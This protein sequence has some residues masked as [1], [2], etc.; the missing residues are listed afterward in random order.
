M[1]YQRRFAGVAGAEYELFRL[2]VPHHDR[3]QD[4]IGESVVELSKQSS[5]ADLRVADIGCGYGYTSLLILDML[6]QARIEA[7][8][9]EKVVTEKAREYLE[10]EVSA[11]RV[12]IQ[13]ADAVD[14]LKAK[15]ENSID[16][17][18]SAWVFHN[19]ELDYRASALQEV[20]RVL[21]KGGRFI[22]ADKYA[23][24]D[25]DRQIQA[26]H[27]QVEKFFDA[28]L[29]MDRTDALRE[30]VLHYVLDEAPRIQM[31]EGEA[32]TQM[33]EIGYRSLKVLRREQMELVL[34][35][36]KA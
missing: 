4:L 16:C 32:M 21:R 13:T 8:D 26:L 17:V 25:G 5:E 24:D 11:Q 19:W 7:V 33:R 22:N 34:V 14:F 23:W 18:V 30:W 36:E 35:A 9:N 6:P 10:K 31:R 27:W 3:F 12:A 1:N 28:Y 20:Y 15:P 29:P 2:A